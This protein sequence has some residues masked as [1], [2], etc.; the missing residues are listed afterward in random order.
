MKEERK[1]EQETKNGFETVDKTAFSES[2]MTT[3][4]PSE[5]GEK[6]KETGAIP[7]IVRIPKNPEANR[8]AGSDIIIDKSESLLYRTTSGNRQKTRQ[9]PTYGYRPHGNY[10]TGRHA[11]N[12]N[13]FSRTGDFQ[14]ELTNKEKDNNDFTMDHTAKSVTFEVEGENKKAKRSDTLV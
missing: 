5:R 10:Q 6:P 8:T 12:S 11:H 1:S 7:N 14:D 4:T 3:S 9:G 2:R 13:L